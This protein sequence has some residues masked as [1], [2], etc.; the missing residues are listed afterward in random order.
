MKNNQITNKN[1]VYRIYFIE[2]VE[3]GWTFEKKN[4]ESKIFMWTS[5]LI[6]LNVDLKF[7]IHAQSQTN[8]KIMLTHQILISECPISISIQSLR[9][10]PKTN[11]KIGNAE[12]YLR[13]SQ[14]YKCI[15]YIYFFCYLYSF[16]YTI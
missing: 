11:E 10:Y 5:P 13:K 6:M 15:E 3:V 12:L 7:Q 9:K 1:I 2:R 4:M 14:F 8:S 16:A